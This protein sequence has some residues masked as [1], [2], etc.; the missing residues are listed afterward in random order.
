MIPRNPLDCFVSCVASFSFVP[1]RTAGFEFTSS[2][3]ASIATFATF[4]MEEL[5][6]KIAPMLTTFGL[7]E[8]GTPVPVPM[9]S[10]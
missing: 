8:T 7:V 3:A 6:H 4:P 5:K 1:F 2:T 9:K 10:P